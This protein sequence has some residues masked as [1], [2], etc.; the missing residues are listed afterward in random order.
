M[1]NLL[2][3]GC[4]FAGTMEDV[5]KT[6]ATQCVQTISEDNYDGLISCTHPLI[7]TMNGD[8]QKMR[9]MLE[10]G[11]AQM[12]AEGMDIEKVDIGEPQQ[13]GHT[14]KMNYALV[15]QQI[16]IKVPQGKLIQDGWLLGIS[17]DHGVTWYFVDATSLTDEKLKQIFPDLAGNI[18]LIPR[19]QPR[20]VVN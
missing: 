8:R 5:I 11:G 15:P 16:T 1:P 12:L 10:A 6:Q 18:V 4:V 7:V 3:A 2:L 20:L 17:E 9:A 14:E 13:V 19:S